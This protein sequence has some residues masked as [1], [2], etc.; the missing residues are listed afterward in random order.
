MSKHSAGSLSGRCAVGLTALRRV[1]AG[2]W[3]KGAETLGPHACHLYGGVLLCWVASPCVSSLVGQHWLQ[4][5]IQVLVQSGLHPKT[6]PHVS[7]YGSIMCQIMGPVMGPVL[8]PVL[9]PV[10]G[11]SWVQS[12]VQ[13]PPKGS[14]YGPAVGIFV[15]PAR[16][17]VLRPGMTA[18]FANHG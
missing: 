8:G 7:S 10:L 11:P 3:P 5:R 1:G 17:P 4:V 16:V 6:L 14:S 13:G 12:W 18:S 9:D 15:L 2:F